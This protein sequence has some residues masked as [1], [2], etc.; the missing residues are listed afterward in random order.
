[1]TAL[2]PKVWVIEGNSIS[3]FHRTL[4][5]LTPWEPGMT[6]TLE[7]TGG[8]PDEVD[9]VRVGPNDNQRFKARVRLTDDEFTICYSIGGDRP[10]EVKAGEKVSVERYK[11]VNGK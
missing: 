4:D 9:Y 10:V 1:V 5:K 7:P 3:S 6:L 2:N 11:R 8:D